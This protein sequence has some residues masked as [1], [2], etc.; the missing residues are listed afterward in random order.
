MLVFLTS[1][2]M[3]IGRVRVS[4][5][6]RLVGWPALPLLLAGCFN[7]GRS[8]TAGGRVSTW[9]DLWTPSQTE[10]PIDR[11]TDTERSMI[12]IHNGGLLGE[13]R[14]RAPCAWR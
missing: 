8:E 10:K 5:L 4:E 14:A 1:L 3:L 9:I 6:V 12:A 11:L 2:V 7:L 13:G